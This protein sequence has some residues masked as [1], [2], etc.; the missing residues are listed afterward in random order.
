[1]DLQEADFSRSSTDDVMQIH[2]VLGLE[3]A[4]HVLSL[5]LY[6][7]LAGP[8]L[9]SG[10]G[11][12]IDFKH[13]QLLADQMCFGPDIKGGPSGRAAFDGVAGR[14]GNRGIQGDV[15]A[16]ASYESAMRVVYSAAQKGMRDPLTNPKS[17]Q[18]VVGNPKHLGSALSPET[19]R[20]AGHP[21]KQLV[22]AKKKVSELVKEIDTYASTTHGKLWF[23]E[24]TESGMADASKIIKYPSKLDGAENP[25]YDLFHAKRKEMLEDVVLQGLLQDYNDAVSELDEIL[26]NWFTDKGTPLANE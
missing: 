15:V 14:K 11:Q 17:A 20:F 24:S 23:G 25:L 2:R 10:T 16:V 1:V 3:A 9:L 21:T 13:F 4:R 8:E 26:A 5:N 6:A 7:S 12:E 22:Y 18:L 19:G